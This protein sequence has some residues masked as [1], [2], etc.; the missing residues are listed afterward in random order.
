VSD[1][2]REQAFGEPSVKDMT[3]HTCTEKRKEAALA[4]WG[5]PDTLH[6]VKATFTK[7]LSEG[8]LFP[9]ADSELPTAA[10]K[11]LTSQ[12]V[13][14]VQ[15]DMLPI[16]ALPAVCPLPCS[17]VRPCLPF[18]PNV[19][20]VVSSAFSQPRN[21]L[22]LNGDDMSF[23]AWQASLAVLKA[24]LNLSERIQVN[25]MPSTHPVV[26]WGRPGGYVYQKGYVEFF[27]SPDIFKHFMVKVQSLETVS[28]MA[29]NKAGDFF[30][31]AETTAAVAWGVFAGRE[32]VQPLIVAPGAFKAW[33]SEA[34]EL[35]VSM[36]GAV[37]AEGAAKTLLTEIRDTW[38]LVSVLDNDYV[39][40]DVF[41]IAL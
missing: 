16:V 18:L 4:T 10:T 3:Q 19:Q 40:G 39:S 34:L 13:A 8:G 28:Y 24:G 5:S 30:S 9:W 33:A 41:R 32:I 37:A 31:D 6:S 26:G 25:G 35:W 12:L 1:A 14:M 38:V 23:Q 36:W 27:C 11:Q 2:C 17:T 7:I 22:F 29:A 20:G 15:S 21:R